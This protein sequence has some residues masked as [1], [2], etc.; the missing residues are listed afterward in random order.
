MIFSEASQLLEVDGRLAFG[1]ILR[2]SFG[3]IH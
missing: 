3:G 2:A 1:L